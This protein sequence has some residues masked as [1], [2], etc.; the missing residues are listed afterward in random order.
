MTRRRS[1]A[2]LLGAAICIAIV[3]AP[4]SAQSTNFSS[5]R[6]HWV[7]SR[8]SQA[9]PPLKLHRAEPNGRNAEVDY[10]LGTSGC[11]IAAERRW[12]GRV[13]NF[14]L[15][16]Y[17]LTDS[18]RATITSERD[19]C[20]AVGTMAPL[21]VAARTAVSSAVVAGATARGKLFNFGDRGVASYP[22][23]RTRELDRAELD[24]GLAE[25][26]ARHRR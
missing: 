1:R 20:L 26:A 24:R 15:Y 5:G 10:M 19:R 6:T 9:L 22:A 21:S 17:P 11:R 18:S 4:A 12:G 8:Y 2:E 7:A 25:I 3:A 13:L 16:S 23:R 14:A